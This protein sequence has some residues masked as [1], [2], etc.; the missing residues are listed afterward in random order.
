[1]WTRAVT[2]S[3]RSF[4]GPIDAYLIYLVDQT[5]V[6][7][8]RSKILGDPNRSGILSWQA[9]GGLQIE[10]ALRL[11]APEEIRAFIAGAIQYHFL[12]HGIMPAKLV[13]DYLLHEPNRD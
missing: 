12:S 2:W 8:T 7:K 11:D 6:A 1:M 9:L 3:N 13:A 4:R 5:D 10:Q